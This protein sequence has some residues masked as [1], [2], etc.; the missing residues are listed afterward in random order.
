MKE[1]Y[2]K[3]IDLLRRFFTISCAAFEFQQTI[4]AAFGRRQGKTY[5]HNLHTQALKELSKENPNLAQ[6]DIYLAEMERVTSDNKS[7][8]PN[9]K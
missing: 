5:M 1:E 9:G 3:K 2:K 4:V 7:E 8:L 6:I